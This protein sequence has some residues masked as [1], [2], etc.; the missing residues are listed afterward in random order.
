M[1]QVI[2]GLLAS[3]A[4]PVYRYR[5]RKSTYDDAFSHFKSI[6]GATELTL[7]FWLRTTYRFAVRF[8]RSSRARL[9]VAVPGRSR[10]ASRCRSAIVPATAET[11][12]LARRTVCTV[13]YAG[14]IH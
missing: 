6:S 4:D 1:T 7:T 13:P 2:I 14:T 12:V 5:R 10:H 3:A 11:H 8:T 9:R